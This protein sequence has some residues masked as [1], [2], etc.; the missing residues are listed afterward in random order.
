MFY[1]ANTGVTCEGFDINTYNYIDSPT[2]RLLNLRCGISFKSCI[3]IY[4][5]CKSTVV[6]KIKILQR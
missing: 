5:L 4:I 3:Y 6:D 2:S 1:F